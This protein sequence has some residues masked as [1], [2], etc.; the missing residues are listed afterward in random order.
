MLGGFP[1]VRGALRLAAGLGPRGTLDFARLLLMPAQALGEE[2]FEG[3][4]TRAW[5]YGSAMHSDVPPVERG[6]RDRR[7]LHEPARPRSRLA[8]PRGRRREARRARSSPI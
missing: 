3:D 2:L 4:G 5:L 7:R 1:P 6:Q 8:Q